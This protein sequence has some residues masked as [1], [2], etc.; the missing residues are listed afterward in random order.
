MTRPSSRIKS[1]IENWIHVTL[2]LL[3]PNNMETKDWSASQ[4]L[5]SWQVVGLAARLPDVH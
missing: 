3:A 4:W 5:S 2:K 1:S